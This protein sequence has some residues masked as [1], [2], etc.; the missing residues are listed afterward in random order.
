MGYYGYYDP[1][2][3]LM[4]IAF[5]LTLI[6]Q[7]M[8]KGCFARYSKAYT[9]MGLTGR[10]VAERILI[11]NGITNVSI[12]PIGASL[13]DHYDPRTCS[14]N[15]SSTVY[16][17]RSIA[18]VAVAAHECGHAI[19]HNKG[20]APLSIRSSLVPVAN[21]GSKFSWICIVAGLVLGT[22]AMLIDIG[23]ILF[24]AAVLFQ[25]V[26]LPVEFNASSRALDNLK[27]L[28]IINSSE[29]S[30][31]RSMLTAAALTYVAAAASSILQLLR[32]ILLFGGRRD[33]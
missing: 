6:A 15:L 13:T 1:T 12:R 25:I 14:V 8:V 33:D 17:E 26:T 30:G 18:A 2:Y 5:I 10:E 23:I 3:G 16:D 27:A 9:N 4:I 7:L 22:N 31:A 20:Y 32:L 19:Q 21:I 11:A 29:L 28:N 24:S